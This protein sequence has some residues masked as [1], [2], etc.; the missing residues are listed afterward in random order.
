MRRSSLTAATA[1]ILCF[2]LASAAF[3]QQKTLAGRRFSSGGFGGPAF[4]LTRVNGQATFMFGGGGAWLINHVFAIG[5]GGYGMMVPV[6][7]PAPNEDLNLGIA[8]G[9]TFLEYIHRWEEVVHL[10][11]SLFLGGGGAT[12]EDPETSENVEE[13]G[14]FVLEPGVNAEL[15]ILPQLRLTAG[16]SYRYTAGVDMASLS[17]T[18]L[19]CFSFNLFLKFGRF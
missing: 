5:G 14:F 9:G 6:D 7:P 3:A 18:D 15:N 13:D 10:T 12:I 2:I 1:I 8:Y 16:I 4:K 17:S 11:F 19:N